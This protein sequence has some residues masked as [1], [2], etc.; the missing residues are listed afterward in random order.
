MLYVSAHVGLNYR[1]SKTA[2]LLGIY[3]KPT[4]IH[5]YFG[6]FINTSNCLGSSEPQHYSTVL[7]ILLSSAYDFVLP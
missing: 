6:S 7:E 3:F 5:T 1:F 2:L 4:S